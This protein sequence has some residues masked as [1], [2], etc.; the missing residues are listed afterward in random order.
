MGIHT[1]AVY[2]G[3]DQSSIHVQL[4]EEMYPLPESPFQDSYLN[5]E[6]VIQ[7]AK[8]SG[9]DAIHP[10][11][12]L[13]SENSAFAAAVR[14]AG[15]IFV[16]PN[17]E[18]LDK[19]NNE[20]SAREIARLA[21]VRTLD[22]IDVQ[23]LGAGA[24][25]RDA[26]FLGYPLVA[27]KTWFGAELYSQ[28]IDNRERLKEFLDD[29]NDGGNTDSS[30]NRIHLEQFVDR[31]RCLEVQIA[32]DAKGEILALS[33]RECSIQLHGKTL[34][35]ESP[36]P[37]ITR[38]SQSEHKRAVLGESAIAI[39]QEAD[40]QNIGTAE[41]VIDADSRLFFRRFFPRLQVGHQVTELCTG[42]NLV[43]LQIRVAAGE[44]LPIEVRRSQSSGHAMQARISTLGPANGDSIGE[45]RVRELRW[46]SVGRGKLRF[47][48]NLYVGEE[49][50]ALRN[51][52]L[53]RA[54][55]Y[56]A[57]RHEAMLTLD[58]V[59]A[60]TSIAPITTNVSILRKIIA[61]ESFRS[62]QYDSSFAEKLL[63]GALEPAT[64]H[65]RK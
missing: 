7:A 4:C 27:R 26:E 29:E 36:A 51:P 49:L 14:D 17:P 57:T 55:T 61:S 46:P 24:A 28:I 15:L 47:E 65:E 23:A 12:G 43:E 38:L 13:L 9:A 31:P 42:I 34:I 21:G 60:E 8:D 6:A 25:L 16:G 5:G 64:H 18:T 63:S 44:R 48:T 45:G 52:W 33:E 1:V 22:T 40:Y 39:A 56:S 58:R 53:A 37:A 3:S 2:S 11:Y 32:A 30:G 19:L 10:G 59:L 50:S 41:F 20:V 35:E 62:G 54:A